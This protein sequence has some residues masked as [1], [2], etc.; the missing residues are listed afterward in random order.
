MIGQIVGGYQIVDLIGAGGMAEVYRAYDAG[1][2]RHV[3][4]KVLQPQMSRDSEFRARFDLEARAIAALEHVHILPVYAYG[5]HNGQLYLI[6]RYLPTGSLADYVDNDGPLPL[7]EVGRL[8]LDVASALDYAHSRGILHRDLKT[9]NILLDASK[10]PYLADFGLARMLERT[11]QDRLTGDFIVGTPEFMSPE[12]CMGSEDLT[13]ATDQYSL[14]IVVFNILTGQ[15]PFDGN[16]ALQII[17]AQLRNPAP[18]ARKWRSDLPPRAD[19]AVLRA[20]EKDGAARFGSCTEFAQTFQAT[21]PS[22]NIRDKFGRL[23]NRIDSALEN[24]QMDD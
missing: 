4:I 7:D 15:L 21:L 19:Q 3:A 10:N 9:E 1:M 24:L 17:H 2:D 12:Q 5:E 20:L 11:R 13:P 23:G 8:L 18:S 22:H 6:M 14:G 16:N